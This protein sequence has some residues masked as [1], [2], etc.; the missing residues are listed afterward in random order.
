MHTI[1]F[2]FIAIVYTQN[3]DQLLYPYTL[4]NTDISCE[5]NIDCFNHF[6]HSWCASG[7]LCIHHFCRVIPEF[8][9]RATQTCDDDTRSCLDVACTEDS[10]CD[11]HI[12]CD[13]VEVCQTNVCVMDDSQPSCFY[14]GGKC[15]EDARHC[16]LPREHD[17]IHQERWLG[18]QQI[19]KSNANGTETTS[20]VVVN[21]TSLI[22]IGSVM[23]VLF[24]VSLIIILSRSARGITLPK[25]N[26]Y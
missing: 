21:I 2:L 3:D 24:I 26:A 20:S 16:H 5:K 23:G 1:L 9:C 12:F 14:L 17:A 25:Q 13:G 19:Q 10:E 7:L 18:A 4:I 11:N 6:N 22:V 8:P 15:D